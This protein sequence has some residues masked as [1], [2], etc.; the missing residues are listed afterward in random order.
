[1]PSPQKVLGA[2]Y[3]PRALVERALAGVPSP[4]AGALVVDLSCGDGEWLL[5]AAGRWPDARL[6]G[7]DVD[8]V[9]LACAARRLDGRATLQQADGLAHAVEPADL[10]IGNPPW[11]AGR[12]PRVRRG[13]ESASRFVAR[14]V[15]QLRPGGRVCLILPAAWL[16]VASHAPARKRLLQTTAVER[17]ER[18]GDVFAG[19]MAPAA[20]VVARR[21]LDADVRA[22]SVVETP[23]G[24]VRQAELARDGTLNP[25]LSLADRALLDRLDARSER[26]RGRARFFLGV[27]TGSNRSALGPVDAGGEPILTG[28]D[29]APLELRPP[30]LALTAPLE[31]MQ[32]A[33]PRSLYARP[34]VVYRFI[35][36]HPI[37]AVDRSGCITLN[38]ANALTV[39]DPALDLDFVAGVLNSTPLRFAHV[40]RRALLRV[41][42][43]HVE[44]LPLPKASTA[45]RRRVAG[46]AA[47]GDLDALDERVM[48]LF[49]L[50]DAARAHLRSA[51][52]PS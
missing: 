19:V 25:R 49:A 40:A 36:P 2:Y 5:A 47:A 37:A 16:E 43:S 35:A 14:A 12:A 4:P 46:L 20:L 52:P 8:P 10:M 9:A 3:T 7:I 38:S 28:R 30:S 1:V 22:M 18:L 15:E 39:E 11:G 27:V 42:R 51:C 32:Q 29:V 13:E 44:T 6:Y 17:L 24:R 34:K 26:L 23:V 21:E 33:A 48:D 31:R 45:E 50:D 41:L